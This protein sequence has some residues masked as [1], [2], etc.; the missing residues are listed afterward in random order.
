MAVTAVEFRIAQYS[1]SKTQLNIIR[2]TNDFYEFSASNT[3]L[4]DFPY[5][6]FV[7]IPKTDPFQFGSTW[8]MIYYSNTNKVPG[9]SD[10]SFY[11]VKYT[12]SIRPKSCEELFPK[13]RKLTDEE[14]FDVIRKYSFYTDFAPEPVTEPENIEIKK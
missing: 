3:I 12:R 7:R 4:I 2:E 1:T 8:E 6:I 10:R 13:Y 14:K 11:E 9:N 5:K